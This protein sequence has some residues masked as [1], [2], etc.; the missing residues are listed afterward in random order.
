MY[1]FWREVGS[2]FENLLEIRPVQGRGYPSTLWQTWKALRC[3]KN[4]SAVSPGDLLD[5]LFQQC[6]SVTR[7]H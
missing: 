4:T 7:L 3:W 1:S 2:Q 6:C 5:L